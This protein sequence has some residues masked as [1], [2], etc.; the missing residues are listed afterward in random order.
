MQPVHHFSTKECECGAHMAWPRRGFLFTRWRQECLCGRAG[1]WRKLPEYQK[2]G[3]P[4]FGTGGGR[5]P[6]IPIIDLP[7]FEKAER[8]LWGQKWTAGQADK[9]RDLIGW[10]EAAG[11]PKGDAE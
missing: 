4:P 3:P 8:A 2:L 5:M 11:P 7:P 9:L 1:P 10:G 6:R